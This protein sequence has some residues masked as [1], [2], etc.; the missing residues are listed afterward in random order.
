MKKLTKCKPVIKIGI[1][2]VMTAESPEHTNWECCSCR[3]N[4]TEAER[5]TLSKCKHT[6]CANCFA[7]IVQATP[8]Y[9][10]DYVRCPK[11]RVKV[12]IGSTPSKGSEKYMHDWAE[13]LQ[14]LRYD[15]KNMERLL[16]KTTDETEKEIITYK[17]KTMNTDFPQYMDR[18]KDLA[19][20]WGQW[21]KY[22]ALTH[23][24]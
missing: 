6:I 18:L 11:C 1:P 20:D 12:P 5:Y 10:M 24:E 19:D 8:H 14:E 16:S 3:G 9:E 7:G 4:G 2:F 17:L 22:E 15:I 21:E 13:W 23:I